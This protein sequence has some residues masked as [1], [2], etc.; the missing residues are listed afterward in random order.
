MI[1]NF[2]VLSDK[3]IRVDIYLSTL[4]SD[5]SRSYIQKL[6]DKEQVSVNSKKIS[7][8]LKISPKDEISIEIIPEK[9][10]ILPE[11]M[12]L[13][14]IFEDKNI[15]IINKDAGINVHPV[16]WEWWTKNTLVNWIL[17]HSDWNL[18]T[19]NWVE[20]PW[21]VHRLDKDTSWIILIAKNDFMMNY[22]S[23]II[24]DRKIEKKY[25]AIVSWIIKEKNIR[26]ESEI[27]RDSKD[28]KK[29]TTKNPINPKIAISEIEV[30]DYI[31]EKY[32][33]L[34]V[35][36]L[37]GRT[38]QIRVH[39]SSIWFPIIWD[40]VYGNAKINLEVFK[41]YSLDRQALHAKSLEFELY[42]KKV[43]FESEIKKDMKKI[44]K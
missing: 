40:K 20:R 33:L 8:N 6:I 27:W 7:K 34:E 41:K 15:L 29:M 43:F 13:D 22:L 12:D 35:K 10:E 17:Y 32:T 1:I 38:H 39:L 21:I 5:Y 42:G 2:C 16:P 3:K 28:R 19:I 11:K 30:I 36:I 9:L 14:I 44:L 24:K 25:F 31:D 37:T 23:K 26:I 18:W 4:F